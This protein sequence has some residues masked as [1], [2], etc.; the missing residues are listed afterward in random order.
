M[1]IKEKDVKDVIECYLEVAKR[2]ASAAAKQ[3]NHS[4]NKNNTSATSNSKSKQCKPD[5]ILN[6]KTNR[7]V[8]RDSQLG[9]EILKANNKTRSNSLN[10]MP[11]KN[12]L[13]LKK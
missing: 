13:K 12:R 8:K 5:Q 3:N 4:K 6:P 2:P 10:S 9:K 1:I 7:C 11:L